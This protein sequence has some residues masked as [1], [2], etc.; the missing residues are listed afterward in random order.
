L[1]ALAVVAFHLS[2]MMGEARYGGLPVFQ[3]FTRLGYL[4]VD[5]FFVLSG[6][7]ILFA[8]VGDIGKPRALA[9]YARRR[10]IR[11]FPVYWL[12]T[13][14]FVALVLLGAGTHVTLPQTPA[15]WLA[16]FTLLRFSE[17]S[18][19]LPVAWTLFHELAFYVLFGLL[20]AHRWLGMAAFALWCGAALLLF[21]HPWDAA[22]DA[23]NVYTASVNLYF[24]FGMG[25]FLLY[26]TRGNGLSES[27]GGLVVLLLGGAAW[28]EEHTLAPVLV[29]GA[30]A[31][32]LAGVA[33]LERSGKLR[34]P[35][36]L[37]FVGDASYSLYL[38]HLPLCGL[39]L[40]LLIAVG[41][42]PLLGPAATYLVVL[43]A[44]VG[45]ACAAYLLVE[46]PLINALGRRAAPLRTAARPA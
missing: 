38:L 46:R 24:V 42:A 11:L 10:F 44:T 8:H 15:Q 45:L 6:F 22:K 31:L 29:A 14:I 9:S 33:K 5:F 30:F 36:W 21:H 3:S 34:P 25:A 37:A 1:A 7:I 28:Q 39:L 23:A 40:K 12:Y 41:L 26:R 18:P 17:A 35:A 43:A 20:I 2:I 13:G 27:A 16:A 32:G 19:P 4:G